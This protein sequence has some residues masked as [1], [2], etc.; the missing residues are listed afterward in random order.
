[1]R[2][3]FALPQIG[4][5]AGPDALITVAERAEDLG[6]DGLWVLDRILYPVN[7]QAPYPVGDGTLPA[8][9]KMVLDPLAKL[10][11]SGKVSEGATVQVDSPKAGNG[12][13]GQLVFKSKPS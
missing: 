7:P 2:L 6:F 11:I 13:D 3:G 8:L 4:S 1:M 9:Y 10:V 12:G 5:I